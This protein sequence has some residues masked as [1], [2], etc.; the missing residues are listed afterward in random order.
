MTLASVSCFRACLINPVRQPQLCLSATV[1]QHQPSPLESSATC[2]SGLGTSANQEGRT[3]GKKLQNTCKFRGATQL[4]D[5]E[6][7]NNSKDRNNSIQLNIWFL[8]QHRK[9]N[10]FTLLSLTVCAGLDSWTWDH[11]H[12]QLL[13]CNLDYVQM[14]YR[15]VRDTTVAWTSVFFFFFL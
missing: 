2:N 11:I 8:Q 9:F 1:P 7:N 4:Q 6:M 12:P 10:S 5:L 13:L 3:Y 14:L 15:A